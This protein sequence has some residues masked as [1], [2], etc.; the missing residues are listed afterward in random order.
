MTDK[1]SNEFRSRLEKLSLDS[2]VNVAIITPNPEGLDEALE[3]LP[4][5]NTPERRE[6][7]IMRS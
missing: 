4:P 7:E 2:K 5:R 3:G 1:I 6:Q